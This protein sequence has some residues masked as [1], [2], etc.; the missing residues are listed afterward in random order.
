MRNEDLDKRSE[1]SDLPGK[2]ASWWIDSAEAT[3]YPTLSGEITVDA[4]VVGGG[5]VGVTTALLLKQ[6]GFTV[7]LIE[8]DRVGRGVTGRTTAKIT[9]LHTLIYATLIREY[10]EERARMYAEANQS[11]IDRMEGL[12]RDLKIDC[13]FVRLPFSTFAESDETRKQVEE[14]VQAAQRLGLPASFEER[15]PLPVDSRGA[16]RFEGQ[17][18]FHPVRYLDALAKRIPGDGSHVFEGSRVVNIEEGSPCRVSTAGGTVRA[19]DAVVATHY[20]IAARKDF[21]FA[22][23]YPENHYVLGALLS[24]PFPKGMYIS[25][26]HD[27]CAYRAAPTPQGDLLILTLGDHHKT[28]QGGDN[29]AYYRKG[30]EYARN[31]LRVR[32]IEYRW[33]T[34]GIHTRD[35]VPYIGRLDSSTRHLFTA[36]GFQAWGMSTGTVAAEI[37][38]DLIQR[39]ENPRAPVFDPTRRKPLSTVSTFLKENLNVGKAFVGGYFTVPRKELSDIGPGSGKVIRKEGDYIGVYRDDAGE[40][41]GVEPVCTHLGCVVS[42]NNAERTWDCPCHGSRFSPTGEVLHSPTAKN[43][44]RVELREETEEDRAAG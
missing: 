29:L 26:E 6:A 8:A 25:A 12:V 17:A 44:K 38:S 34:Q 16:V 43:L 42:W 21:Y 36:T 19:G 15:I 39:K 41:H 5:I 13:D 22:R 37:L 11:A 35:H 20:P 4:A 40:L 2:P 31:R 3:A 23:L 30:I 33:S 1:Q 10:G 32:S 24:E 14:E 18:Q 9:S 28:G 7:A 27:G